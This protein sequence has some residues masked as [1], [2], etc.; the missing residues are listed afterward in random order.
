MRLRAR[1]L[2]FLRARLGGDGLPLRLVFWDGERFDFSPAPRVTI[3]LHSKRLMRLLLRGDFGR[4]GDAY[5][6][7]ELGVEG[8]IEE[9]LQTGIV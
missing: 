2:G 6:A 9:V 5:V 4:L 3:T 7:G 8:P 1:A